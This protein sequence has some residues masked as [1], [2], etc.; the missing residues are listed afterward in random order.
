M[1]RAA[2]SIYRG[3]WL[4][5]P[6]VVPWFEALSHM[7]WS[8][9]AVF[10][11]QSGCGRLA[12]NKQKSGNDAVFCQ[13]RQFRL[14]A[15]LFCPELHG[16]VW[17]CSVQCGKRKFN[18][19]FGNVEWQCRTCRRLRYNDCEIAKHASGRATQKGAEQR[20][21]AAINR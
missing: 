4:E 13:R 6:L 20:G 2:F 11:R 19:L 1:K 15:Y 12:K 14:A 17:R 3:R 10:C 16:I 8:A 18:M 7:A 21:G 5:T 9:L